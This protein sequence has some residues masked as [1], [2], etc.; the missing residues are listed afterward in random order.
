MRRGVDFYDESYLIWLEADVLIR[1][2]SHGKKSLNDFCKQFYG[3]ENSGPRAIPYTYNDVV[4]SLNK[5]IPYD[6]NAFFSNRLDSLN[7]HAPLAGIVQ[8]GWN[9]VY[10]ESP[11]DLQEI[12]ENNDH[13]IDARYSIGLYLKEDGNIEDIIPGF[14]AADAG[15]APG[16]N[17]VAINGRKFSKEVFRNAMKEAKSNSSPMEFLIDN[18]DFFSVYPIIYHAGERYPVLERDYGKPD[19]LTTIIKPISGKYS[20]RISLKSKEN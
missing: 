16:M 19:V 1:Q 13:A 8:S 4:S 18:C 14:P 9:L 12:S 10:R 5:I 20:S 7:S 17:I 15:L 3:G 11:G 6:W 2:M